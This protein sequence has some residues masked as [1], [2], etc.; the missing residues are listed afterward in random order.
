M[1]QVIVEPIR[2]LYESYV[3]RVSDKH[4]SHVKK[5]LIF[6]AK[7]DEDGIKSY[8]TAFSSKKLEPTVIKIW[9]ENAPDNIEGSNFY[10]VIDSFFDDLKIKFVRTPQSRTTTYRWFTESGLTFN[11]KHTYTKE[12][13]KDI[14]GKAYIYAIKKKT[15]L[16]E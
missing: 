5:V 9:L 6:A 7:Y 13:L 3:G 15:Q 10:P 16:G 14:V 8:I 12:Q 1:S 2:Q 11:R 4:W